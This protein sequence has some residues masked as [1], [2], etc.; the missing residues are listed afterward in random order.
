MTESRQPG[1]VTGRRRPFL[2]AD[3][4]HLV[5]LHWDVDPGLLRPLLP[6]GI[7]LDSW[8][9]RTP[10]GLV[11]FRFRKTRVMG[12]PIPLHENFDEINLRFYV[13]RVMGTETRHGVVFIREVVARPAIA[14]VARV[15]Y[16]E[17]YV[18]LPTRS[19]VDL[20]TAESGGTGV[21]R[22]QWKQDRWYTLE[23]HVQGAPG[24]IEERSEAE[25]LTHR[26][27]GYTSQR[28]GGTI[29]YRVA[30]QRWQTWIP[31]RTSLDCDTEDMYGRRWGSALRAA[32]F[33]ALLAEGSSVQVFRGDRIA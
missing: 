23:A 3:W 10:V 32:P 5:M 28:D 29:E 15:T 1:D 17:P 24:P 22:Y 26:M 4:C 13:R 25:F 6:R 7:E 12:L 14:A 21:A 31:T 16:N 2:T 27:W 11:G 19:Y 20:A 18:A 9:G 30:H 33:S 8:Q